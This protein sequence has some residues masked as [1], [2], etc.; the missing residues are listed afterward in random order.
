MA[1]PAPSALA[2][3]TTPVRYGIGGFIAVLIAAGYWLVFF[4]DVSAKIDSA[5]KQGDSLRAD[6]AREKEAQASYFADR[7]ELALRQQRARELNKAL[8]AETEIATFLSAIQQVANVSGVDLKGWQPAEEK[9][10]AFYAKVP[11]SIELV[12]RYHQIAKFAYEM[13]RLERII[14][15]ENIEL[16]SPKVEG[17]EVKLKAKC[18]ATTFHVP[19]AKPKG[20][21]K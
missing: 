12:G 2:K 9:T 10:E 8:P 6:L 13:G 15:I 3:L 1:A 16:G 7:D 19:K 14:N 11:M 20:A 18:L 4:T 21:T 17:D 5:V